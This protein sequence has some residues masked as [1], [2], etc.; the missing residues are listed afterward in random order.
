[1][2]G[3]DGSD[4]A[5]HAGEGKGEGEG[6]GAGAALAAIDAGGWWPAA[7]RYDSPN[8][9]ARPAGAAVE[10]IVLHNI[11]LPAG[12]FGGPH[13]ADLFSN[14][15]DFHADP[16]F[17]DLRGLEVSAHFLVRRDGAVIQFVACEARA[18]HAGS[19]SFDG[20][21]NC[22]DFSVGIE[23]EG[24]DHCAFAPAQYAAS[25][26]LIVALQARYR[27]AAIAGHEHI[28]PGRKSDPGPWFDWSKLQQLVAQGTHAL[29][30]ANRAGGVTAELSNV[31]WPHP[32]FG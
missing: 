17:A 27:I 15:L 21:D 5:C 30:S 1:M 7:R 31:K 22:N 32:D 13:I 29:V 4:A 18:W 2:S 19:S 9:N 25:A 8:F 16:T 28:A 23:I 3:V 20:R 26:R 14:R 10:L 24:S 11:S 12:R 6:A